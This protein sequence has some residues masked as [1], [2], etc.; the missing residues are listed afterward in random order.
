MNPLG[1]RSTPDLVVLLLTV[2]VAFV[3]VAS[4]VIGMVELIV[5]GGKGETVI[6]LL[7]SVGELTGSLIAVIV[8]YV[9]GRGASAISNGKSSPPPDKE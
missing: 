4:T 1:D 6:S 7:K 9:G 3:I 8:G 2:V 5:L